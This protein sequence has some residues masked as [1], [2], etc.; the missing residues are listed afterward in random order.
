MTRGWSNGKPQ[1]MRQR[2]PSAVAA[3]IGEE[4]R[5][6]RAVLARYTGLVADRVVVNEEEAAVIE[7]RVAVFGSAL[8]FWQRRTKVRA[9]RKAG[10]IGFALRRWRAVQGGTTVAEKI[11][12][13]QRGSFPGRAC[14][15]DAESSPSHRIACRRAASPG[16]R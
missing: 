8:K 14:G 9:G 7:L 1:A 12:L 4:P 13:S 3:A 5:P 2:K 16:L 10:I 11:R 6:A 15:E